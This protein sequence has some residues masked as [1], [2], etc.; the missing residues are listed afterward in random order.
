MD[1]DLKIGL[2]IILVGGALG[3]GG[4]FLYNYFTKGAGSTNGAKLVVSQVPGTNLIQAVVTWPGTTQMTV[5]AA[6][7]GAFST[8]LDTIDGHFFSSQA[9]A[10]QAVAAYD[11]GNTALAAQLVSTPA[12]RLVTG[13]GT[14]TL[15][16]EEAQN[17][18]AE[19]I[20]WLVAGSNTGS[21]IHQDPTGTNVKTSSDLKP[22]I[23]S[24][25]VVTS[26]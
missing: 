1:K 16:A 2:G 19:Y 3:A 22:Y 21:L 26:S 10:Q 6:V 9:L 24:G 8:D 20:A 12:D 4:Y 11:A 13:T 7:V 17:S 23:S 15:Y 5:Q 25:N 14:V 18:G